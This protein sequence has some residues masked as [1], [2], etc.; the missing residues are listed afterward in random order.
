MSWNSWGAFWSMGGDGVYVWG[1]YVVA[2]IVAATEIGVLVL[3][4]RAIL[5][6]LGRFARIRQATTDAGLGTGS[7]PPKT[8]PPAGG[9]AGPRGTAHQLR[10]ADEFTRDSTAG[11]TADGSTLPRSR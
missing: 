10:A 11:F 7:R 4:R 1:A 5:A 6:H 2:L 9:V 3:S 8:F